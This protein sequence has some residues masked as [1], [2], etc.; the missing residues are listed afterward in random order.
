MSLYFYGSGIVELLIWIQTCVIICS[1]SGRQNVV[2]LQDFLQ[3]LETHR[4]HC[5]VVDFFLFLHLFQVLHAVCVHEE[6]WAL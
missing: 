1:L 4:L 6:D 5:Y 2:I 3:L